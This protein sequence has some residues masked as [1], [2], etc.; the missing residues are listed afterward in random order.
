MA[1]VSQT[2]RERYAAAAR[3]ANDMDELTRA[4]MAA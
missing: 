4:D 2:V 3:A 1:D